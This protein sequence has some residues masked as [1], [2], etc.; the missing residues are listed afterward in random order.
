VSEDL[1]SQASEDAPEQAHAGQSAATQDSPAT[2][3]VSNDVTLCET[4]STQD[5]GTSSAER[6][7]AL[8]QHVTGKH[9]WGLTT[10]RRAGWNKVLAAAGSM[11][12]AEAAV[13]GLGKSKFHLGENEHGRWYGEP[14][15]VLKNLDAWADENMEA[16]GGALTA[17]D[18]TRGKTWEQVQNE[19]LERF[20]RARNDLMQQAHEATDRGEL[21]PIPPDEL[22]KF[23]PC[24]MPLGKFKFEGRTATVFPDGPTGTWFLMFI[25]SSNA[26]AAL[27]AGDE[28]LKAYPVSHG[29]TL[30]V[31]RFAQA[32]RAERAL[33]YAKTV[34]EL[35]KIKGQIFNRWP[36]QEITE[37]EWSLGG[38]S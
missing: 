2:R 24:A 11:T 36:E 7:H 17:P 6:L 1:F 27:V 4:E 38:E 19:L 37:A 20:A 16:T 12:R 28:M 10:T 29:L 32:T 30:M 35:E 9:G 18:P 8:W 31:E 5:M 15:N 13:R 23:K 14:S 34:K 33:Q 3:D 22:A 25:H 21:L 26:T